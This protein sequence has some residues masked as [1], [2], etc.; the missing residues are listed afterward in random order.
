MEYSKLMSELHSPVHHPGRSGKDLSHR[1]VLSFKIGELLPI[2]CEEI[3]P[4]DY[5][6]IDVA[7]MLRTMQPLQTAAFA[8]MK[9]CYDFFF[10]PNTA[11]WSNFNAYYD[12]RPQYQSSVLQGSAY[13]PNMK[14]DDIFQQVI[15]Q[16]PTA[17]LDSRS[18]RFK[19]L[20]LLGYSDLAGFENGN[21]NPFDPNMTYEEMGA[22]SL[23]IIPI[24]AYNLIYNMIYRN[25][26]RDEPDS[27]DRKTY[28][29][30]WLGC[31][32]YASSLAFD[33][34]FVKPFIQMHYH[35]YYSDLFMGSL[36][37]AQFGSVSTVTSNIFNQGRIEL[38]SPANFVTSNDSL[39]GRKYASDDDRLFIKQNS[40]SGGSF[41]KVNGL[42]TNFDVIAL[43][44]ALAF[45]SWKETNARAGWKHSKQSKAVYGE[46]VPT[47]HNHDVDF[48]R[49]YEFPIMI[50]EVTSTAETNNGALGDLAGKAIGVDHTEKLTFNSGDRHGYLFCIAYIQPESEYNAVGIS[51]SLVRSEPFDRFTPAFENLGMQAI[52]KYMLNAQGNPNVFGSVIGY[53]PRYYDY[54]TRVD[55]VFRNF[56]PNQAW[57]HWVTP[58][59]DLANIVNTGYI[60]TSYFYVNPSIGN[61]VFSNSVDPNLSSDQFMLNVRFNVQAVR[62]MSDLGLPSL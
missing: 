29:L 13:E 5:F 8:R 57:S 28:N 34:D 1:K 12:Q 58:R 18:A 6:E 37:N 40:E 33:G 36:P 39:L 52:Q 30:D 16:S 44:K 47:D 45:Q 31:N 41:L 9:M 56:E 42:T 22:K 7:S 60:P 43:R 15:N 26:W 24:A 3:L 25:A 20:Q 23:T 19:M 11:V 53:A 55:L 21:T 50:D 10:V 54:K 35:Q 59:S 14:I 62:G 2:L 49:S 27:D 51:P 38:S 46:S 4:G 32:S 17:V 48:L 61:S